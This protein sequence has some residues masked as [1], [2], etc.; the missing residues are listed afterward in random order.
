MPCVA[1]LRQYGKLS[2]CDG[3]HGMR[4]A[5]AV[6][7]SPE[8]RAEVQAMVMQS[9]SGK[10]WAAQAAHLAGI[11]LGAV[12]LLGGAVFLALMQAADAAAT[13]LTALL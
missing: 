3:R 1:R 2:L 7:S 9:G 11:G 10:H 12:L 5:G 8:G 13:V 4:D 6:L